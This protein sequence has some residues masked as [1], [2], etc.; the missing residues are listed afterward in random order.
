[1]DTTAIDIIPALMLIIPFHGIF[2]S[3]FFLIKSQGNFTSNFF[4]GLLLLVLSSLSLK[5]HI[6]LLN[7]N[8]IPVH[9]FNCDTYTDL[10]LSP[11]LFLYTASF[12][13]PETNHNIRFH[14][15][16]ILMNLLL[17][18]LSGF[19]HGLMNDLIVVTIVIINCQYLFHTVCLFTCLIKGPAVGLRDS[20]S[21]NYSVIAI[22]N[23]LVFGSM[24]LAALCPMI[25]TGIYPYIVQ[26]P[27]GIL[28]YY[29]YYLILQK[30]DFSMGAD[31]PKG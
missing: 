26:L 24:I 11:F 15:F 9:P 18:V 21:T 1:M 31:E 25:C 27:K 14:L 12:T 23:L 3:V 4:I 10:L 7:P 2:L 29:I 17:L 5:P 16:V 8:L 28:I 22:I 30:S 19:V 13:C 6:G 20:L